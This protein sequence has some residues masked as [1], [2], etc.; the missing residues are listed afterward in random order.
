MPRSYTRLC[1]MIKQAFRELR[2]DH[3]LEPY[4]LVNIAV[5]NVPELQIV[6]QVKRTN[7][8][9]DKTWKLED[10][11]RLIIGRYTNMPWPMVASFVGRTQEAAKL[12]WTELAKQGH[13]DERWE[14]AEVALLLRELTL[15]TPYP[16]IGVMLGRKKNAIVGKVNRLKRTGVLPSNFRALN[17]NTKRRVILPTTYGVKR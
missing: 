10:I 17:A 6:D 3:K 1:A 8:K 9:H 14:P 5:I 11:A 12:K 15:G 2:E 16:E 7:P 13:G 4:R